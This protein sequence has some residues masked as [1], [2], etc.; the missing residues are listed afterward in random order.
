MS[1]ESFPSGICDP[2]GFL[3]ETTVLFCCGY[4]RIIEAV[5][6]MMRKRFADMRH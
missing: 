3:V 5:D 2:E 1:A 4:G 6:S